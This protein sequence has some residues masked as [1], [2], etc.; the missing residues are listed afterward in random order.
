MTIQ[1]RYCHT[2]LIAADWHKLSMFYQEVFGC[3]PVP[4]VR[5]FS[6]DKLDAGTGIHGIHLKGEHLRLPGY[7]KDGPTLEIF[8]YSPLKSHPGTI[9]NR[10]GYGHIAFSVQNVP[11][12][13]AAVLD[14]GGHAV[15]EVVELQTATGAVVRWC[16]VT[17]I[18][19]NI[20]ELQ[21]WL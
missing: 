11:A 7:G 2:N 15:G 12:A 9:V 13:R 18:E 14:A 6:G 20:I 21:S 5:D 16:Y 8:T 1:A 3:K 19:G 10:P 4:P 17:D